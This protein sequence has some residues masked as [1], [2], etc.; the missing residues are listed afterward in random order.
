M[1]FE[2]L[3]SIKMTKFSVAKELMLR[4]DFKVFDKDIGNFQ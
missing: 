2:Q 3:N 4:F 1:C